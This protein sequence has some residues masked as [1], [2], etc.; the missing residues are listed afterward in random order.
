MKRIKGILPFLKGS[1][2]LS[3][4]SLLCA[5]V[6][7]GSKLCI[8][9][10]A[11]EA[12]NA[13]IDPSSYF[14]VYYYLSLI[15]VF[16]LLGTLFRYAF[17][18]L[19]ALVG[20]RV[21]KNMRSQIF[22]SYISSPISF[23]DSSRQGNLLLVLINDVEN[24]QTGLVS[25]FAAFYDGII[26]ILFTVIFMFVL[27]W[28]LALIVIC[29]TPISML[30]SSK[31]SKFNSKHFKAQAT[32]SGEMN[33]YSLESL[34]NSE[35]VKTLGIENKRE[36]EFDALNDSYRKN[37]FKALLGAATINPSTRLV[38]S[39]INAIIIASGALFVIY[40]DSITVFAP[41]TVGALSSFLSYASNYMQ[42]FNEISDVVSEI[43]YALA[44]LER[45]EKAIATPTDPNEGR[46]IL[47]DPISSLKA[48][49][50]HFSYDGKREII[51]DFDLAIRSGHKIALV[52]PTGCGKTTLINL[53]LRFYDPQ[54]GCFY[55]NDV[56]TELLDKPSFR[57]HLGMVLQDTWIFEGTVYENIAYAKEG[58]SLEEVKEA[59]KKAQADS[60]IERLPN[61]Y[62]TKIN[63]SSGLSLGEKQL[64]CVARVM[65][66]SPEVVIL[67]EA[68]SNIDIR[69]ESLLNESFQRLLD[70]KTSL[71]VA[72]RLSTIVSSDYIVVM[73]DGA[74]IEG[75]NHR[76]LMEKKGF[77]YSLYNAQFN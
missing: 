50:L 34:N 68:T 48:D 72:H 32:A 73:K 58:A 22:H 54:K 16:L 63:D 60:F 40:G 77:Y 44:S 56:S 37:T 70:G 14:P 29:L 1:R 41:L 65:L 61:G 10:L 17:D 7:T 33:A 18:Y 53:L 52:G 26:A 49:H 31:V 47:K 67:D 20:Q 2:L 66:L 62:D 28:A 45:I 57:S 76:E 74:I 19:T 6:A 24:V 30:V 64:L 59:A 3:F 35:C 11:G 21:I 51:K 27:N 8:P 23:V 55:A 9:L 42:P 12:I 15:I 38:N 43:D 39:F 69:T 75:G 5:L 25:G 71:V 4:L 36:E 46:N 13:M